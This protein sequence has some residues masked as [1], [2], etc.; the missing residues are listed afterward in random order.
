MGSPS[1][2]VIKSTNDTHFIE[3]MDYLKKRFPTCSM[4]L[5]IHAETFES[6][7]D[8][9]KSYP[10]E[11][12]FDYPYPR[13]RPFTLSRLTRFRKLFSN[14][15]D[16]TAVPFFNHEGQGYENVFR[17]MRRLKY[18]NTLF[19]N[20]D[21]RVT[22]AAA[23]GLNGGARK[24]SAPGYLV[25]AWK[26][27]CGGSGRIEFAVAEKP[28]V[29]VLIKS[30]DDQGCR[31]FATLDSIE[32]HAELPCEIIIIIDAGRN[33]PEALFNRTSNI[34][35]VKTERGNIFPESFVDGISAAR[36]KYLLFLEE[37]TRIGGGMMSEMTGLM[38][39][40]PRIGA[41]TG[42][43][44]SDSGS[45]HSAGLM[46][47][48]NG[49]AL[50]PRGIGC[51]PCSPEFNYVA[52]VDGCSSALLLTPRKFFSNSHGGLQGLRSSLGEAELCSRLHRSGYEIL[53]QSRASAI[54]LEER[55][56]LNG[57]E[58]VNQL[59]R[60]EVRREPGLPRILYIDDRVP[61]LALGSGFPR[62]YEFLKVLAKQNYAV[63]LFPTDTLRAN[64]SAV[65]D[66]RNL[67]IEVISEMRPDVPARPDLRRLLRKRKGLYDL[68]IVSRPHNLAKNWRTLRN[69]DPHLKIVYDAEAFF[70]MRTILKAELAGKPLSPVKQKSLIAGE[71]SLALKADIVTTVSKQE[72]DLFIQSG[73]SNAHIVG[74]IAEVNRH[75]APFKSRAGILFVG[76]MLGPESPNEDALLYFCK[77]IFPIIRRR[78]KCALNVIGTGTLE[79]PAVRALESRTIKIHGAVADLEEYYN[80]CRIFVAPTRFAAGIPWKITEAAARGIPSV[81][82]PLIARQLGWK[83]DRD[84]L[85][86]ENEQNFAD[87]AIALYSD[88]EMWVR[89]RDG[90]LR[91]V[92][93]E[94][95]ASRFASD[96]IGAISEVEA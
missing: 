5:V 82:T 69:Y 21:R 4:D 26:A 87:K 94:C 44:I 27:F 66:L 19:F 11:K 32:R 13:T 25:A 64:E 54:R 23:A 46:A 86:G 53:Y 9:L 41:V 33:G 14:H 2:L 59:S 67:G 16:L 62:S 72:Q 7:K 79:R 6:M 83:A 47:S 37:G 61:S 58:S 52:R 76:A 3:L 96:I 60:F 56:K 91:K 71:A 8:V 80:S 43:I 93:R 65:A 36:G 77:S 22:C 17:I 92:Q 45:L 55:K 50:T 28:V 89:I 74:H 84:I 29:S 42:K 63:T 24:V 15:Y 49:G 48:G 75:G 30:T 40:R 90:G 78:L 38:K 88:P 68:A 73:I 95:S 39:Q 12:I 34:R 70:S 51:D 10:V 1:I 18:E 85:I 81:V 20:I 31:L 35:I 57:K